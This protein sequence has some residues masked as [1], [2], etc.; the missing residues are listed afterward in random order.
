MIRLHPANGRCQ[1]AA[2]RKSTEVSRC[3]EDVFA[4]LDEL[5]RHGEWQEDVVDIRAESA[6]PTREGSKATE[7]RR[8]GGREFRVSYVIVDHDPPRSFGFRVVTGH[9]RPFG[10]RTI[11]PLDGGS[12]SRVTLELDFQGR[13][14]ARLL[15]PLVRRYARAHVSR[16]ER[17]LKE[18]LEAGS[19]GVAT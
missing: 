13:G 11:E 10:T 6:G 15:L 12:R 19:S 17:R 16:G 7:T 14:A 2:I 3:P 8:I 18:R 4:Y 5:S 1:I 9:I